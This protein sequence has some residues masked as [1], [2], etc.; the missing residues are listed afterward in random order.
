MNRPYGVTEG[1]GITGYDKVKTAVRD[2]FIK[3]YEPSVEFYVDQ[4]NKIIQSAGR[5]KPPPEFYANLGRGKVNY[6]P[7]GKM[8]PGASGFSPYVTR[9][10]LKITVK[11]WTL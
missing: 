3:K 11:H 1:D 6:G 8:L 4:I 7:D 10:Q 2:E 5:H 9:E